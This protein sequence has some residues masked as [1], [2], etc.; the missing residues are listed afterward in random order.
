MKSRLLLLAACLLVGSLS[1][2]GLFGGQAEEGQMPSRF[3]RFDALD[4]GPYTSQH[5][6][7]GPIWLGIAKATCVL[8][9]LRFGVAGTQLFM[10]GD[11]WP[12]ELTVYVHAG[13]S[14]WSRP[15]KTAFF[16][17]AAPDVYFEAGC[18]FYQGNLELDPQYWVFDPGAKVALCCDLDYYGV[19]AKAE[20]G[21]LSD[22]WGPGLY[23]GFQVRLLTFGIGF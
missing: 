8:N 23:A 14:V 11:D 6:L 2:Q 9:R 21:W 5:Y 12:S 16:Y 15:V 10:C 7:Q 17:G 1:A 19:G 3:I 4:I 20:I 22:R 18:G 13:Y